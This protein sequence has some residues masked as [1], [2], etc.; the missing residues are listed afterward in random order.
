MNSQE[1][2]QLVQSQLQQFQQQLGQPLTEQV[3]K[4]L[5]DSLPLGRDQAHL[6]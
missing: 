6:M 4:Q 5:T 3:A 2:T 1:V